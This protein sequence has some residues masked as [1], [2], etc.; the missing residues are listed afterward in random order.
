MTENKYSDSDIENF[1][2]NILEYKEYNGDLNQL[3]QNKLQAIYFL[4]K[5]KNSGTISTA[6]FKQ[7]QNSVIDFYK[8][9][10][11]QFIENIKT[12]INAQRY[13]ED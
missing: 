11:L 4:T 2:N 8:Y 1:L 3:K 9:E 6:Q 12:E 5:M 10:L 13:F 7:Y